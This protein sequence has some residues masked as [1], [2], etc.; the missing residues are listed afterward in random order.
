MIP[1]VW[2]SE[3]VGWSKGSV[4][5]EKKE[6]SMHHEKTER[7]FQEFPDLSQSN[8]LEVQKMLKHF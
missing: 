4:E 3:L 8:R 5:N 7:L 2:H 1:L 6:S